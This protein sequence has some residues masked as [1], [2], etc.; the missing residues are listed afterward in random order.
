MM[1]VES[2]GL[3]RVDAGGGLPAYHLRMPITLD[4]RNYWF[5][6]R[7]KRAA[8]VVLLLRRRNGRYLVHTKGFYPAGTWR[9]MT[10]GVH[11]GEDPDTAA[12]READEETS[13]CVRLSQCLAQIDYTFLYSDEEVSFTSYLYLLDEVSGTLAA[14]DSGED[15]TGYREV[16]SAELLT[17]ADELEAL[18][19][20]D[21]AD[22]GRFRA[23][24]HRV[25]VELLEGQP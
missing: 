22:W 18:Q 23:A 15:I 17:L 3:V 2:G 13:L 8:E 25:A 1:D 9:L 5:L 14:S 7:R 21:W 19:G 20:S 4:T 11:W 24:A 16:S 10:G 12:L 6:A